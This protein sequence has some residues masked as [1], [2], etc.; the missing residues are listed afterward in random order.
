MNKPYN[1]ISKAAMIAAIS[2]S[3]IVPV[4]VSAA[5]TTTVDL[6]MVLLEKDGNYFEI[7][8]REYLSESSFG[9]KFEPVKLVQS[10]EGKYYYLTDYLSYKS[11]VNGE[12]EATFED[13]EEDEKAI[14]LEKIGK[15]VI[16]QETGDV[17]YVL[18]EQPEDRLN[19]TFFYNFAA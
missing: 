8:L 12:I 10:T 3:T 4:A 16:D 14:E 6:E 1:V 11:F 7:S 2:A 5:E 13:L 9:T 15:V 19:E 17:S 18:D